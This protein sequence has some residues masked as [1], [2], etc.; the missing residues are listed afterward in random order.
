MK[1]FFEID[2]DLHAWT[3]KYQREDIF[4]IQ[5]CYNMK[6]ARDLNELLSKIFPNT[7]QPEYGR[8]FQDG[9]R[10][11]FLYMHEAIN[12]MRKTKINKVF[13]VNLVDNF[14]WD[15]YTVVYAKK[16]YGIIHGSGFL[17]YHKAKPR[18]R[19]YELFL[20]KVC[21]VFVSTEWFRNM[22]PY[23][24]TAIG[25]PIFGEQ[26][27]PRNDNRILSNHRIAPDKQTL[28]MLNFPKD[29]QDRLIISAPLR[30]GP[31]KESYVS[32]LEKVFKEDRLLLNPPE[33]K[34][35]SLLQ[36]CGFGISMAIGDT[37]GYSVIEGIVNGLCYFTL[38]TEFT[39]YGEY[40]IDELMCENLNEMYE[41]IR[42]YTEHWDERVEVVKRQQQ[43]LF[44]KY[45]AE[46]WV[47]NLLKHIG[48]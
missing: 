3:D 30:P 12:K 25:L 28:E 33:E 42:Y 32:K 24:A 4:L 47:K 21:D 7:I 5:S 31:G 10:N 18:D 41:K 38:K 36:E 1:D 34:Y 6:W 16:V 8:G 35:K 11:Q 2:N 46:N 48:D 27:E 29:I 19:E 43:I 14:F 20:S 22:I 15:Y 13:V 9:R 26:S 17:K 44:E 45:D 39:A 23:E 37:F 40:M